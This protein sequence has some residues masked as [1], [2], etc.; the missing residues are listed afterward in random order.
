M[1]GTTLTHYAI[2]DKVG[3]GGMGTVYRA[4][5][6]VLGRVVAIK[7]LSAEAANDAELGPRILRE[8]KA[9]SRLN[10]PNIVTVY[11]LGRSGE[12]E[13]LV[14]EYVEGRSLSTEIPS[15]GLP[16]NRVVD[17][18]SQI[19]DALAAAHEAGLVHRDMK[20]GNV[21]V[22]PSGRVKVLDFGLA[23]HLPVD[24]GAETTPATTEFVTRHGVA[25]TIGYMAPE[26]IEGQPA[27]ARSDVFA[28]GIV[29]FELLT[30]RRPFVGDTAWK[31]MQATVTTAAPDVSRLRPDTPPALVRIVSRALARKPEDRYPS[32]RE[33][34]ND[35]QALRAPAAASGNAVV[36]PVDRDRR[37]GDRRHWRRQCGGHPLAKVFPRS[38]G[39]HRGHSGNHARRRQ[40]RLRRGVSSG[41][42]GFRD[43][44]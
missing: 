7:V 36:A 39:S 3:Q 11:E 12:T 14:M 23:R 43:H 25:G 4:R 19:A 17:Y 44:S 27:D 32:A 16:I 10:H 5:D 26:Q 35:L 20:P 42:S 1:I 18:A 21:M 41:P 34:A 8:A 40:R 15:G 38:V 9:A 24:A 22:T 13:F 37:R 31:T 29:I 6:T 28:L 2:D 30:G 33:L